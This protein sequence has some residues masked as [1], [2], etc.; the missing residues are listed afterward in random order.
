VTDEDLV[1]K[2]LAFIGTCLSELRSLA[3]A[4]RI[5]VDVKERRFVE[6]TLQICIQAVQD[7]ASHIV[8][9]ERLGEPPENVA[10]FALLLHA[11]W[12]TEETARFLRAAVG[13]RN[14]LVHGYTAVD[15]EV[16]RDVLERRLGDIERFVVEINGR[17][18]Q[19]R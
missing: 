9:D 11:G 14:V 16:V 5:S 15:P 8:S 12:L 19:S 10:I 2:K 1:R 18:S 17:L 6:H 13:F 7:V 4:E 3:R